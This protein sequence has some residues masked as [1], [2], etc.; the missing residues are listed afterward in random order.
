MATLKVVDTTGTGKGAKEVSD[1][2]FAVDLNRALIHDVAVALQAHKRQGTHK[3][4]TRKE[5][6]GGGQKPFRQ[7]G[8]GRARRGSIREPHLRGGGTVFGPTPRSYRTKITGRVRRQALRCI[9]SER[10]R[11]DR[12]SVLTGLAI[13]APKT[14]PIA[15]MLELVAPERRKTLLVSAATD[16]NLLLSTRNIPQVTV[17]T[18]ADVNAL[19]V[20]NAARVIVQEEA[21]GQLEERL[22]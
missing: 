6:R 21:L 17:R 2:V 18:A 5:V 14:K 10:A 20:L 9:L 13:E 8:T 4:K 7:K 12:L 11:D 3:T 19:D 22:S 1:A 16:K 15:D